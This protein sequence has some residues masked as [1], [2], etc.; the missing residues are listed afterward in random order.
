[1]SRSKNTLASRIIREHFGD[2]VE[3]I[4]SY[5][6]Q[7]GRK[8]LR[9]ICKDLTLSREE[10]KKG[11]SILIQHH[12]VEYIEGRNGITEYNALLD[13]ILRRRRFQ[14]YVYCAKVKFGDVA[15][16]VVEAFLL[17]GCDT[18][19]RASK[20][21]ADRLENDD[22][23]TEQRTDVDFVVQKCKE[24]IR[25][26][27]LT[28]VKKPSPPASDEKDKEE[29]E[30]IKEEEKF[31]IP[32]GVGKKRKASS[33]QPHSSKKVKLDSQDGTS[34]DEQSKDVQ[35]ED[36]GIYWCLNT[37]KFDQY[38]LDQ[39]II[40]ATSERLDQS[41]GKIVSTMLKM[42]ESDRNI[43]TPAT[44][45]VS[46]Y[47][48]CKKMP[49]V[50]K[51]DENEVHQY[52]SLL[53]DD[54]TGGFVTKT[55]EAAGG[56]YAVN[57]RKSVEIICQAACSTIVQERFGSKACR[58]FRLLLEKRHLEQKQIGELAM[59]PFKDV[60]E[61]L[62]KL[63]EERMVKVQEIT[64]T[65]DYAPSRTFYLFAVDLPQV[66]RL[67]MNRCFQAI[68]NMMIRRDSEEEENKRLLEKNEKIEGILSALSGTTEDTE[69]VMRELEELITPTEK[70]QLEKLKIN[71]ARL[72]QGEIQ[73]EDTVFILQNH[74]RFH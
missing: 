71:L 62:Y 63:F 33:P 64:K 18:L 4:S 10:I 52:L 22:M 3:K 35:Y 48:L 12:L 34:S 47:D 49:S 26:Q 39:L 68:G 9:E 15:E 25:G 6:L 60:K 55:D 24:L 20:R 44:K 58:V 38:F 43:M 46:I 30:D 72:E 8:S 65:S 54:K 69:Q 16:L 21:V 45:S 66:V 74:L 2:I 41:A 67:L 61:L 14:K 29:E 31:T 7:S 53:S 17:S 56:M 36:D 32:H 37:Q 57:M 73:I 51:L 11:L 5:L 13:N 40:T 70:Q 28:R 59:I 23:E 27:Y 42:T 19:S 50:P 1:M